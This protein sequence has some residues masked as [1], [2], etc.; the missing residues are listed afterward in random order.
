MIIKLTMVKGK[1][2]RTVVIIANL[3]VVVR[4]VRS[5]RLP[6]LPIR[7]TVPT[8]PKEDQ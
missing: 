3:R 8:Y 6:A 1:L 2:I 4:L 7:S 5:M